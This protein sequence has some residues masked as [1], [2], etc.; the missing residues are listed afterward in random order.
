MEFLI[1]SSGLVSSVGVGVQRTYAS[2]EAGVSRFRETDLNDSSGY[3]YRLSI[4]PAKVFN[5]SIRRSKIQGQLNRQQLRLLNL[6]VQ[7][8]NNFKHQLPNTEI[9][10]F[11]AGP[12][13]FTEHCLGLNNPFLINIGIQ[14]QIAVDSVRSRVVNWGRAGAAGLLHQ[15]MEYFQTSGSHYAILGGVDSYYHLPSLHYLNEQQRILTSKR[16]DGFIPGE[17]AAFLLLISPFAPDVIRQYAQGLIRIA[18][19]Q[20]EQNLLTDPYARFSYVLSE[21]VRHTLTNTQFSNLEIYSAANGEAKYLTEFATAMTRSKEL[22]PRHYRV[23]HPAENIGDV[24]AACTP[25]L[26]ALAM[27]SL[28]FQKQLHK[29]QKAGQHQNRSA[30]IY[31]ASDSGMRAGINLEI[32]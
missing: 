31:T 7:G 28:Q 32:L 21:M 1:A 3:P 12:E 19:I 6:A 30:V 2:V 18:D 25:L 29:Q 5:G 8:I 24:G 13:I 17:A 26:I 4:I 11:L 15:V 20:Q 27:Q 16:K 9:P 22:L 14:A 23:I 10:L